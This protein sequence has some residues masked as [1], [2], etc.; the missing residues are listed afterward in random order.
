MK[1]FRLNDFVKAFFSQSYPPKQGHKKLCC[2]ILQREIKRYSSLLHSSGHRARKKGQEN[3]GG[4]FFT[5]KALALQP[6]LSSTK[7]ITSA[8]G[9][10]SAPSSSSLNSTFSETS[11]V[12]TSVT[13]RTW[14]SGML[15]SHTPF[16]SLGSWNQNT[17]IFFCVSLSWIFRTVGKKW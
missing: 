2:V 1:R 13:S 17:T 15:E 14:V 11:S 10:D 7:D 6:A 12:T 5:L 8:A 3:C 16:F 4:Y 9:S